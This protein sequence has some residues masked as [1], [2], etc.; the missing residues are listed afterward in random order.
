M[1]KIINK[2]QAVIAVV[3]IVIF[4]IIIVCQPFRFINEKLV[5][6][7]NQQM[8]MMSEAVGDDYLVAQKFYAPY[9][10]LHDIRIY[11]LNESAGEEFRFILYDNSMNILMDRNVV[12][13]DSEEMPGFCTVLI[14]MEIEADKEYY[15]MIQGISM[16]FYLA[17]EDT[18]TSGTEYNG[19]L[20]RGNIEDTEHNIIAEYGYMVPIRMGKILVCDAIVVLFGFMISFLIKKY[21]EKRPERNGLLTVE[22]AFKWITSPAVIIGALVCMIAIWPCNLFSS[23]TDNNVRFDAL[24]ILFFESGVLIAAGILLYGIHH[25]RNHKSNDMGLSILRDRW[26]DYLQAVFFAF[27]IQAGV[28]YMNALSDFH[29][30]IAYR[31][32]LIYFGLAVIMTFKRKEVLNIVNLIYLVI[33]PIAAYL[34]YRPQITAAA[35]EGDIQLVQLSIKAV[36]IAGIVII[37]T[38]Y[39]LARRRIG[40]ISAYGIILTLLFALLIIFR[41]TRNWPIYL[42]CVFTPY[43]LRV[44]AWE[45]KDRL[46]QNICNGILLHF[47]VMT[48][49]CLMHRPYIFYIQ[50]RFSFIFHTVTITAEYLSLVVCAALVRLLDVYSREQKLSYIWKELTIFG[51][52]VVYLFITLSRTGYLAVVIMALIVIPVV[53]LGVHSKTK[54]FS[55]IILMMLMAFILCFPA[56]FTAQRI[57]PAVVAEPETFEVEWTPDDIKN[58]RN[59]NSRSYITI[60]RFIQLFENKIIGIPEE[61]CVAPYSY[62]DSQED[63]LA[64]IEGAGVVS[65]ESQPQSETELETYASGRVDIFKTYISN[66]NMTG[67]D[68]MGIVMPDGTVKGYHAHNTY[69]QA[70]YDHGIPVGIVFIVFGVC[71]FIQSALYYKNRKRDRFCSL[72]PFALLITFAVAGLTEWIFHPCNPIAFCMM[73]TLA[74]LLCDM[75]K[76]RGRN[77]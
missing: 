65:A 42:V 36:V 68:V 11:L 29:H 61:K 8:S 55:T 15:Y 34:Y 45:K 10:R 62:S 39:I 23:G 22:T 32:M 16:G 38:I 71:T 69:I 1:N 17:Y 70:A 28:H 5:I 72:F 54:G 64:K 44:S 63:A 67:H 30:D 58:G 9:S 50:T 20:F 18:E 25:K 53:C 31:E 59:M 52:S 49:Y 6:K 3:W 2:C 66:L 47:M 60:R 35:T 7:S 43:Y 48:G 51:I 4:L 14:D 21:Y 24:D 57:I 26:T 33:A 37:N 40:R 74:P 76:N 12:V 41:N 19:T 46:L 75:D 56:V 27:A 73:L 13:D 77:N